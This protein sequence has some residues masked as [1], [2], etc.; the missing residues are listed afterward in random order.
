MTVRVDGD[1]GYGVRIRV[2]DSVFGLGF[3][4]SLKIVVRIQGQLVGC[5]DGSGL[6]L[7]LGFRIRGTV[8]ARVRV[9]VWVRVTRWR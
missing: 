9:T 6:G 4:V 2:K 7:G 1:G 8:S 5:R 3:R